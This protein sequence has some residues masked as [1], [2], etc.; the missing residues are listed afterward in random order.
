MIWEKHLK[1]IK[2]DQETWLC[3]TYLDDFLVKIW[4]FVDN[5][6]NQVEPG[7]KGHLIEFMIFFL[8]H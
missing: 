8:D 4:T 2:L 7:Y 5:T 3:R 1:F 6:A